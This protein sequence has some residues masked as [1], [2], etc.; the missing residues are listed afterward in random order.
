MSEKQAEK[1]MIETHGKI[2]DLSPAT[3]MPTR[4]EQLWGGFNELAR[5]GTLKEE[6]YESQLNDMNRTDMEAHARRVG[7][8]V[9]ESSARLKESLKKEFRI[10]VSTLNRPSHLTNGAVVTKKPLLTDE[11][12]KILAEGR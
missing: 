10:Y 8:L 6:E 4:A 1:S 12:K 3:S 5:Y 7:V 9:V 11:V 2:E